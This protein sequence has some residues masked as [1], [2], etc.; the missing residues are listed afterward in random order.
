MRNEMQ[1]ALAGLQRNLESD[2]EY[3]EVG[4][5]L[6]VED[7]EGLKDRREERFLRVVEQAT[8]CGAANFDALQ[9]LPWGWSGGAVDRGTTPEYDAWSGDD[10]GEEGGGGEE[11]KGVDEG[12]E[13]DVD[14]SG[15][16]KSMSSGDDDDSSESL[17]S[18]D[19]DDDDISELEDIPVVEEGG[20]G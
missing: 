2:D 15:D 20:G 14:I 8:T 7:V 4:E 19:G 17:S 6:E 3:E 9:A 18:E 13:E 10:R 5:E 16:T 12:V 11:G 1:N